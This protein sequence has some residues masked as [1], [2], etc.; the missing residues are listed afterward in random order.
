MEYA[1]YKEILSLLQAASN[2]P[3]QDLEKVDFSSLKAIL[4]EKEKRVP[5]WELNA[6]AVDKLGE[7]EISK[8]GIP[9]GF[10]VVFFGDGKEGCYNSSDLQALSAATRTKNRQKPAKI[11]VMV[12]GNM[13]KNEVQ[14]ARIALLILEEVAGEIQDTFLGERE[15]SEFY[16]IASMNN[17][18]AEVRFACEQWLL[19][20]SSTGEIPKKIK[21]IEDLLSQQPEHFAW[22]CTLRQPEFYA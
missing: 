15:D 4:K 2:L 21:K 14:E 12:K 17:A 22:V 11:R 5:F 18:L 6:R 7:E 9:A 8:L 3:V 13:D 1:K 19:G 10:S 16:W 20:D